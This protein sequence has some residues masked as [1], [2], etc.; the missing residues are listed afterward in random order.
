MLDCS[1]IPLQLQH[2]P[3]N[4]L[5]SCLQLLGVPLGV[6]ATILPDAHL[7]HIPASLGQGKGLQLPVPG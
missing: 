3:F 7:P 5:F 4:L 6:A 2:F 1:Q